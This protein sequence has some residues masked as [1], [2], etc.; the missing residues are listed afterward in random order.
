MTQA[1]A[2]LYVQMDPPP[3]AEEAFHAWYDDHMAVRLAMPGILNAQRYRNV[4]PERPRH[5]A[6]YDLADASALSSPEYLALREP[7][8]LDERDGDHGRSRD[9]VD[10]LPDLH[11]TD[12]DEHLRVDGLRERVVELAVLNLACKPHHVRLDESAN[13]APDENLD[14]EHGQQLRLRPAVELRRVRVDEREH[15]ERRDDGDGRL[16]QLDE[17]VR[18]VLQLVH[19]ADAEEEPAEAER[20]QL[21]TAE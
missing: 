12:A 11:L 4:D 5:L 13:E 20:P 14:A 9:H 19:R 15:D 21:P 6:W 2:L 1:Q 10:G 18:A 16:E 17:E 8:E 7:V 3:G